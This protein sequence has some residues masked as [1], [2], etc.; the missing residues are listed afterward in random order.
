MR[1]LARFGPGKPVPGKKEIVACV[2]MAG[3]GGPPATGLVWVPLDRPTEESR[4][5]LRS[6]VLG[7]ACAVL[8][9][10]LIAVL[11]DGTA[12]VL[13]PGDQVYKLSLDDG[14]S[15]PILSGVD[16]GEWPGRSMGLLSRN[17]PWM[18]REATLFEWAVGLYGHGRWL[19]LLSREP[20][21]GGATNWWLTRI[22]P[23]T[24]RPS[25]KMRL[26]TAARHIDLV[27]GRTWFLLEKGS[28]LSYGYQELT[29][30]RRIPLQEILAWRDGGDL[31]H[32]GW[33]R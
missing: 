23:N 5:L 28:V 8:R 15:E 22:D 30:G 33:P 10:P 11:S 19:Y 12:Y 7:V 21:G 14:L 27:P 17:L 20:V 16:L 25:G 13:V 31:C 24:G 32:Q 18:S 1:R 4:V 6:D 29:G 26:P 9:L 3:R 2:D